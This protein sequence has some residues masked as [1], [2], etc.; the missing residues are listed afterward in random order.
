MGGAQRSVANLILGLSSEEF[1]IELACGAGGP[2]VEAVKGKARISIIKP[3]VYNPNLIKDPAAF[4]A[5]FS[6]MKNRK[7]DIV[8][9]NSTKAGILGRIAAS[10]A[11]VPFIVHSLRGFGFDTDNSRLERWLF[12]FMEKILCCF[13]DIYVSVGKNLAD[14]FIAFGFPQEK[15]KVVYNGVDIE[16][17]NLVTQ[18]AADNLRR[19]SGISLGLPCVGFLGRIVKAK[20]LRLLLEAAGDLTHSGEEFNL[21][22]VGSGC[23]L[24]KMKVKAKKLGLEERVFFLGHRQDTARLLKAMDIVVIPSF[25]EGVPY[26]LIDAMALRKAIVAA[27]V[28]GIS[29][30]IRDGETGLLV[31][32]CSP[33]GI[34]AALKKFLENKELR[35]SLGNNAYKAV[36]EK[37]SINNMLKG[38]ESIYGLAKG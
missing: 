36:C 17:M 3:L 2:L 34:A 30:F 9:T 22:V 33:E 27:D 29:E 11:G 14:K 35:I 32:P 10:F 15:V 38:Y 8:H 31:M 5:L 25:R 28:G 21:M 12:I 16:R 6:L 4:L 26:S 13:T 24:D 37:I 18:E 20:G 19:E 1:E 7:F 23:L